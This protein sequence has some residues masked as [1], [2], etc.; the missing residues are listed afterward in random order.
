[1]S[2]SPEESSVYSYGPGTYAHGGSREAEQ[3]PSYE[4]GYYAGEG[5]GSTA[6]AAWLLILGGLLSFFTG[7]AVVVKKAYFTSLPGYA[8]FSHNYA[9]HWNLSSWGWSEL[10]F[11]AVVVATGICVLMG[12]AWARYLGIGLAVIGAVGTF[13]FLPIFPIWSIIVIAVDVFIIWAL[14]TARTRQDV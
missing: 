3:R 6:L 9:Y 12:L 5:T 8:S 7:L 11:G 4:Q 14:A 10:I 2:K 1:M 13:L